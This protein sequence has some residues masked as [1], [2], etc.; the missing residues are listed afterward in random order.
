LLQTFKSFDTLET[1]TKTIMG[2]FGSGLSPY[3]IQKTGVLE[4]SR[5]TE[6]GRTEDLIVQ[7]D[8]V[9]AD[10]SW[11]QFLGRIQDVGNGWQR[12]KWVDSELKS[13][14]RQVIRGVE[15]PEY[16]SET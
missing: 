14:G 9:N 15:V 1:A 13:Y 11:N 7:Y 6:D 3:E 2:K 5:G 4:E 10:E 16:P 8:S 12:E